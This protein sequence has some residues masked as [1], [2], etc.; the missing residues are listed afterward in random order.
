MSVDLSTILNIS[1][2]LQTA[3]VAE[4]YLIEGLTFK[5]WY[6]LKTEFSLIY[7]LGICRLKV[8]KT[9]EQLILLWR[10]H[11]AISQKT[12]ILI[13]IYHQYYVSN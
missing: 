11:S 3:L 12:L 7:L 1:M 10:L 13:I 8:S 6:T 2:L 9:G 5:L 4:S